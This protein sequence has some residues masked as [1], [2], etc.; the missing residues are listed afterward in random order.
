MLFFKCYSYF[1]SKPEL[2]FSIYSRIR[3]IATL[4][5][6]KARQISSRVI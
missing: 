3:T 6:V 1:G 5:I 4:V 2:T